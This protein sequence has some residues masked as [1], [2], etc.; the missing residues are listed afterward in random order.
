MPRHRAESIDI[1]S[2]EQSLIS[3]SDTDARLS[4]QARSQTRDV[5]PARSEG[6]RRARRRAQESREQSETSNLK[7]RA[8]QGQAVQHRGHGH[9]VHGE[10]ERHIRDRYQDRETHREGD[11]RPHDEK[12]RRRHVEGASHQHRSEADR[13]Q[14][15][16]RPPVHGEGDHRVHGERD[17]RARHGK[18]DL[19]RHGERDHRARGEDDLRVREDDLRV[20]LKGDP[21]HREGDPEWVRWDGNDSKADGLRSPVQLTSTVRHVPRTPVRRQRSQD[22]DAIARAHP[23]SPTYDEAEQGIH[24]GVQRPDEFERQNHDQQRTYSNEERPRSDE[25]CRPERSDSRN[26]QSNADAS[27]RPS[28]DPRNVRVPAH[29]H[30]SDATDRNAMDGRGHKYYGNPNARDGPSRL[31]ADEDVRRTRTSIHPLYLPTKAP[32]S[33]DRANICYNAGDY[34][35]GPSRLPADDDARRTRTSI[36]PPYFPCKAPPSFDRADIGCNSGDHASHETAHNSRHASVL[37]GVRPDG[38]RFKSNR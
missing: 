14:N 20:R 32:P 3:I 25:Y 26:V 9:Q 13:H 37:K 17:H 38:P 18:D 6:D 7:S 22:E 29:S 2:R 35:A 30:P 21:R 24:L 23:D 16:R 19:S 4:E 1:D 10:R 28:T 27:R 31:P 8:L 5:E 11:Q 34:E 12:G 15:D 33:F 36:C